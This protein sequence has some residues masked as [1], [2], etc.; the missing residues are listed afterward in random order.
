MVVQKIGD[1]P[2]VMSVL[3]PTSKH[4]IDGGGGGGEDYSFESI[5]SSQYSSHYTGHRGRPGTKPFAMTRLEN[6]STTDVSS[7]MLSPLVQIPVSRDSVTN[8]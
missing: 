6:C 7:V 8:F 5:V 2:V 1:H 3:D 4:R